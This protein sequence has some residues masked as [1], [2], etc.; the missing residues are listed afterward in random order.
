[1]RPVAPKPTQ[2]VPSVIQQNSLE[3]HESLEHELLPCGA[4]IE[5][6]SAGELPAELVHAPAHAAAPAPA[7]APLYRAQGTLSAVPRFVAGSSTS[8]RPRPR[9]PGAHS[10]TSS[11]SGG[12]ASGEDADIAID[13]VGMVVSLQVEEAARESKRKRG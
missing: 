13:L 11:D 5:D 8:R 10:T 1:M 12:H 7:S 6:S 9:S 4:V 3:P 2:S